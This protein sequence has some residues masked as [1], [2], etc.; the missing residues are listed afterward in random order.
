MEAPLDDTGDEV[1]RPTEPTARLGALASRRRPSHDFV[2]ELG[3]GQHARSRNA[4]SFGACDELVSGKG[5][6][7]VSLHSGRTLAGEEARV[8]GRA[9][10]D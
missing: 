4:E 5:F 10:P 2:D 7:L 1:A 9:I 3:L 6:Q 8:D